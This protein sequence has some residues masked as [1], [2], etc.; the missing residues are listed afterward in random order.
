M[1]V[2]QDIYLVSSYIIL[3]SQVFISKKTKQIWLSQEY[4]ASPVSKKA[5]LAQTQYRCL[6][7]NP[8]KP[9]RPKPVTTD[10][11]MIMFEFELRNVEQGHTVY[12][13]C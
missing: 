12:K 4:W 3:S 9:D 13:Y 1:R 6:A 8:E 11:D 7:W 10:Q 2:K 5:N